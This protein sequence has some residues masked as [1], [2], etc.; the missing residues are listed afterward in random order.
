MTFTDQDT[1]P[2]CIVSCPTLRWMFTRET[3]N[4]AHSHQA[5]STLSNE[6]IACAS[7]L[8]LHSFCTDHSLFGFY[9]ISSLALNKVH[10]AT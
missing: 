1:L 9:D 8:E 10:D 5:T 4:I 2:A 6:I 7:M 3:V